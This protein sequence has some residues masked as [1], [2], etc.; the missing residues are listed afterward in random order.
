[1]RAVVAFPL[2]VLHTQDISAQD[3]PI[4]T[5]AASLGGLIINV[6]TGEPLPGVRVTVLGLDAE[7]V[8]DPEGRFA[9]HGLEPGPRVIQVHLDG[10]AAAPR[11]I[12]LSTGQHTE[13]RISLSIPDEGSDL[14]ISAVA[15]PPLEV[16]IEG[17]APRG[18]LR[19][20]HQRAERGFGHFI[21][22]AEIRD[23]SPLRSSDL[24]RDVPGLV[25]ISDPGGRHGLRIGRN[26]RCEVD[27]YLDG[28]PAPGLRI[29]DVPPGDIGGI[30]IYRAAAEVPMEYRRSTTCAVILIWSRDPAD[31]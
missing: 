14:G 27:Y 23:R 7:T 2:G 21:T 6:A 4:G 18:K 16:E 22:G 20:F 19:E 17:G 9:L 1:M 28:T 8:T 11:R 24:M 3:R 29:D 26:S 12:R 10:R 30:E 13:V 5:S 25:V 31:P 15:L